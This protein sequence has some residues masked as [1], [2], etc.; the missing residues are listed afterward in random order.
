MNKNIDWLNMN[1]INNTT[2]LKVTASAFVPRTIVDIELFAIQKSIAI[3][4]I[5]D[6]G[7]IYNKIMKKSDKMKEICTSLYE[8][9]INDHDSI[10]IVV[11]LVKLLKDEKDVTMQ[12]NEKVE[13][14]FQNR[15]KISE[16]QAV[17][18]VLFLLECESQGIFPRKFCT[19]LSTRLSWT[20][21]DWKLVEMMKSVLSMEKS[22]VLSYDREKDDLFVETVLKTQD[23]RKELVCEMIERAIMDHSATIDFADVFRDLVKEKFT[24]DS[25][26][27]QVFLT[28]RLRQLYVDRKVLNHQWKSIG[29]ILLL[30]E[31]SV[32]NIIG[33]RVIFAIIIELTGYDPMDMELL[34]N[35]YSSV[36]KSLELSEN[37]VT[38]MEQN[39]EHLNTI[40]L[41]EDTP[42][43]TSSYIQNL[44]LL[45]SNDWIEPSS[46]DEEEIDDSHASEYE[47]EFESFLNMQ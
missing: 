37:R 29:A 43:E 20:E 13:R 32:R 17:G 41:N 3:M 12:F 33:I 44:F 1:S 34:Y 23:R 11:Q 5:N 47:K 27:L 39:F 10:S 25:V 4:T 28:D 30:G 40:M 21:L 31:L 7:A 35:L 38:A 9:S 42:P 8:K 36:G 24:V 15:E 16:L 45:R 22:L 46:D 26:E 14:D 18:V 19:D 2:G 6:V